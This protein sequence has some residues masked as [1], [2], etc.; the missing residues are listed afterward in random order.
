MVSGG[1]PPGEVGESTADD[2]ADEP[3]EGEAKKACNAEHWENFREKTADDD[4]S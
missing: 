3:R 4:D 2:A 1:L